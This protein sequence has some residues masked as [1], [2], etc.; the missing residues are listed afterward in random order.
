MFAQAQRL[1]KSSDV[2]RTLQKGRRSSAGPIRCS[3]I[4]YSGNVRVTVIISKKTAK[5][6]VDRNLAKRRARAALRTLLLPSGDLAISLFNGS[7]ALTYQ[8]L[9]QA[10]TICLAKL[11]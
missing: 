10:L 2:M 6:A 9:H 7:P 11:S 3:L 8:Q 5:H 1:G 4:P